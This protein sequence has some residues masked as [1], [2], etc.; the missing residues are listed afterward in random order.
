MAV[1]RDAPAP[2]RAVGKPNTHG[3]R[4]RAQYN[5]VAGR[6]APPL[7][8]SAPCAALA[9]YGGF[10]DG[11]GVASSR[12]VHTHAWRL[13][14][15]IPPGATGASPVVPAAFAPGTGASSAPR[16]MAK[17]GSWGGWRFGL[18][19]VRKASTLSQGDG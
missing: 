4:G 6:P 11:A 17:V 1:A 18:G 15:A 7:P 2:H 14:Q 5:G 12:R 13:G 19:A 16:P 10:G 3:L 9:G 8:A